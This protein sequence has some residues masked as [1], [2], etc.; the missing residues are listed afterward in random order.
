MILCS[1]FSRPYGTNAT[2]GQRFLVHPNTTKEKHRIDYQHPQIR[3]VFD[4]IESD[5]ILPEE[6]AAMFEEY[7]RQQL[8]DEA[9][10][11]EKAAIARSLLAQGIDVTV[12][13]TAIG[14]SPQT[15]MTLPEASLA[16]D[17]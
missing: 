8:R 4:L 5:R 7:N 11:E 6:R 1:K 16:I 13:A 9:R 15:I 12:I 2:A 14:L 10:Q 17:G 3:R